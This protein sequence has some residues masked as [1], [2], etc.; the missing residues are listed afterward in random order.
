MAMFEMQDGG[1]TAENAWD[2]LVN[3]SPERRAAENNSESLQT[4]HSYYNR[5]V[6]GEDGYHYLK[7]FFDKYISQK[8]TV[9]VASFGSGSGFLEPILYQHGFQSAQIFGYELNHSLV[10]TAN[11]YASRNTLGALSYKIAD[12]NKPDLPLRA[13]DVGIFFHSLHHIEDLEKCLESVSNAIR[14]D[15][16]LLVI[17][18]V[19]ENFQ[20]WTDAQ[21]EQASRF[22]A[23][24]PDKYRTLAD[25]TLKSVSRR[26]SVEEVVF[27]D[28]S[29]SVRS[30]NILDVLDLY[31]D[32]MELVSLGG[33]ILNHVFEGIASNFDESNSIDV[34]LI[35]CLQFLEQWF[36]LSGVVST[37]FVF[38]VY[39]PKAV[40]LISSSGD[41]EDSEYSGVSHCESAWR[42]TDSP[43]VVI[44]LADDLPRAITLVID[45]IGVYEPVVGQ[46]ISVYVGDQKQQFVAS[47][48]GGCVELGFE[49]VP[50]S[51]SIVIDIP[52]ASSPISRGESA[53]ERLLGLRIVS[54]TERIVLA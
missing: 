21:I 50:G 22:L 15:G 47:P 5:Q 51:R 53:D 45:Y 34:D 28:P 20:Q 40:V 4:M 7:Y 39:R 36:E 33:S 1:A 43:S 38:G 23:L 29:E 35:K 30:K 31:F 54:V 11:E 46:C 12:L 13:F 32:K 25:G 26:P 37:D 10:R 8:S 44:N 24:I 3:D 41:E 42:W 27:Y 18:F 49:V 52:G 17:E 14:G 48:D 2:A 19:G 9:S 6:T 16:Y